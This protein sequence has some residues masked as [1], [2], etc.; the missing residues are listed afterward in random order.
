LDETNLKLFGQLEREFQNM[1][2]LNERKKKVENVTI[3]VRFEIVFEENS[4]RE[5]CDYRGVIVFRKLAF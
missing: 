3:T 5:S 1:A 4:G 2:L